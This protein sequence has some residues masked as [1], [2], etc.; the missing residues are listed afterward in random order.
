MKKKIATKE[1]PD[2]A[3]FEMVG[4]MLT[5]GDKEIITTDT[6][7][8]GIALKYDCVVFWISRWHAKFMAECDLGRKWE[9]LAQAPTLW[10]SESL[11][12]K[13]EGK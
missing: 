13:E 5:S 3:Y 4:A 7:I 10:N 12:K 9:Q 1:K 2:P 11:Q 6:G 8:I